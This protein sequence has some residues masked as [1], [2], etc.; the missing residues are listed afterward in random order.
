LVAS[1]RIFASASLEARCI[2]QLDL[3]PT[4][5]CSEQNCPAPN[6]GGGSASYTGDQTA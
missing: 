6:K 4:P 5:N 2:T 1:D 3:R